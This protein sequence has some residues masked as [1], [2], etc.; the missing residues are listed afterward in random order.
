MRIKNSDLTFPR[1]KID[2]S[3]VNVI[4]L[5]FPG[6]LDFAKIKKSLV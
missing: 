5:F 1:G 6:N 4:K 2:N 3:D